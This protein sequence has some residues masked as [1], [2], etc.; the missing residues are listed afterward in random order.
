MRIRPKGET[1]STWVAEL[2]TREWGSTSVVSRGI[3]R[4]A[5]GLPAFIAEEGEQRVGLATYRLEQQDCEL[6]TLNSFAAGAGTA[7]LEAVIE[8]G[9]EEHC[10][11]V[12]LITTNDNV[13]ALRF[14]Q[15]RGWDLVAL[16]HGAVEEARK[17]KPQIPTLGNDG[18]PIRHELELEFRLDQV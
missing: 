16:H 14:Y 9:R 6:V 7:L 5:R 4:D 10:H 12:W 13:A 3:V 1:D 17:L 8:S 18:I 15:R 2:L 11:R